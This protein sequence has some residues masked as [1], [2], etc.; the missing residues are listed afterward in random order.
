M[1]P[2]KDVYML[3]A[4]SIIDDS[5]INEIKKNNHSFIPLYQDRRNNIISIMKTKYLALACFDRSNYGKRLSKVVDMTGG[6]LCLYQDTN[7]L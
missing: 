5:L 2:L 6:M 1:I 7:L 3:N 4:N